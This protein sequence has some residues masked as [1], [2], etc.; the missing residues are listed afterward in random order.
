LPARR[1]VLLFTLLL[2]SLLAGTA[3]APAGD[4][5][6]VRYVRLTSPAFDRYTNHPTPAQAAWMRGAFW[7]M[8]AYAPYF[9]TRTAFYPNALAYKDLYAVHVSSRRAAAHPDLLLRDR[10]GR[11]LFIPWHCDG[12]RCPQYAGDITSPAFRQVW[13]ANARRTLARGYRGLFIDDVNL[14]YAVS[15]GAGVHVDPVDRRTGRPMTAT[16]WRQQVTR[17][18]VQIRRALPDA[19]L[20]HNAVWFAASGSGVPAGADRFVRREIRAAD[21]INLERG[22][23]DDSL[24]GGTGR[25]SLHA[26]FA[27][28]DVVH[29][30]HRTVTMAS[31]ARSRAEQRYQLAG[32]LLI[33]AGADALA[34]AVSTPRNFWSG[35]QVQLG[36]AAGRRH[37]DSA[38]LWR[39]EFARGLVLLNEPEA[40]VRTV[41]VPA[42]LCSPDGARVRTVSLRAASGAV[43]AHCRTRARVGM[44]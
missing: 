26:L 21:S 23:V 31:Y 38:G 39:R 36:P 28:V 7:R 19:E 35:Y 34:D 2:L 11:P 41:A 43:L 33:N 37:R 12:R 24:T 9:D 5:G 10:T 20:H 3:T 40:P 27:Y 15:D 4:A 25:F 1:V 32:S 44:P 14:H 6:H 13:I 16:G 22:I 17:F 29:R 42:G 8:V 30:L 18:L